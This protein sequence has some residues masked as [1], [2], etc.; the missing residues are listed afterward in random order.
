MN[1]LEAPARKKPVHFTEKIKTLDE[2][3]LVVQ[4]MKG[5]GEKVVLCHGVFD[6]LHPGHLRHFDA[7]RKKGAW[8]IVTLTQDQYVGKGPGR[9]IFNQQLRAETVAALE[10]VDYVAMNQWPT[11]V[12]TIK[13][14]K[15][16]FYVKGSDYA[17]F[18][19]DL[20]GMIRLEEQAVREIGGELVFTNE[21]SFSSS[22]VVNTCFN[23][24]TEEAQAFLKSFRERYSSDGII[25][26]I[27]SLR[28]LKILVVGDAIVDEY[29]Y[30]QAMG[31]SPK[32]TIVATRY[33]SEESFAGGVLACANHIA[34]FCDEVDLVTCLGRQNSR[35][36]FIQNHLKP[37]V[38]PVFFYRE[39]ATTVIKRRF[40][41]PAFLSKMFQICFL[42][43]SPL[44][45]EVDREL[46]DYLGD[47]LPRYDIV[48]V[49][50]YGHGFLSEKT[51]SLLSE[52]APFL[53]VN[54]QTN[55]SNIGYNL[56]TKYPRADYICIDEPEIRLALQ[57]RTSPLEELIPRIYKRLLTQKVT[58]TRG[59]RSSIVYSREEGF[60][61]IP[62]FSTEIVDRVGAG[63]AFLAV[64]SPCVAAGYPMEMIGFVGN[65]V[66]ALAVRIV[67]N[68]SFIEPLALY[69]F[70][71][72]VL[73]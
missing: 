15:P 8:L 17:N 23:V 57:D 2:L 70:L 32:E 56:V 13:K 51:V 9:P 42:D 41:D 36:D 20:T 49:A 21:I 64:T 43:D 25:K 34:G 3:E 12:E 38:R 54:T 10:C 26:Q 55:S 69:R 44:P 60:K 61:K 5:R 46:Q 11:A 24:F 72:T 50:D 35:E 58:I 1:N 37:N 59:H 39:D 30:C 67:G 28:G 62:I 29:H 16:D 22:N 18:E 48:L 65:L 45:A 31:K 66:G 19:S 27:E 53:A 33:V 7:A 47:I 63:D 52:K 71:N 40:V 6:L 73:K 4:E 68:R 14:L